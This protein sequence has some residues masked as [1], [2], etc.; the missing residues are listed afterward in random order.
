MNVQLLTKRALRYGIID[1]SY[2]TVCNGYVRKFKGSAL[3]VDEDGKVY[4]AFGKEP[5][6]DAEIVTAQGGIRF[7]LL[8]G[9]QERLMSKIIMID[10]EIKAAQEAVWA[11]E[12]KFPYPSAFITQKMNEAQRKEYGDLCGRR[13]QARAAKA[14]FIEEAA[15]HR[16][17]S[18]N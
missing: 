18:I 11:Y 15:I 14:K 17:V 16:A 7:V 1:E 12:D 13:A 6:G 3:V 8:R 4:A 2:S 9:T 5:E 10:Q